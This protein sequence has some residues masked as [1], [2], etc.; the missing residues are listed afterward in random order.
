[1]LTIQ[2]P[3][4]I[5]WKVRYDPNRSW[6]LTQ[7]FRASLRAQEILGPKLGYSLV[8]CNFTDVTAFFVRSDLVG[9]HF[10]AS[11]TS[12]NHYEPPCYHFTI[13]RCHA[14]SILD[15]GA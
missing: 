3:P 13:R 15:R 9:D 10:A 12:E 7:N 4:D 2:V 6:D 14:P 8:G 11:L 5:D 1:M